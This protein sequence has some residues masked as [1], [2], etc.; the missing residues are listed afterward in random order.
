M[1]NNSKRFSLVWKLCVSVDYSFIIVTPKQ[2]IY[3]NVLLS[4]YILQYFL[5]NAA[6]NSHNI[7]YFLENAT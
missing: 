1:Q 7:K 2:K 6:I 3:S 5:K 4:S